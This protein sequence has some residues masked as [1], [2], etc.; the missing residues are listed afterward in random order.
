MARYCGRNF[1]TH[2]NCVR[3]G[4]PITRKLHQSNRWIGHQIRHLKC[5]RSEGS[6]YERDYDAAGLRTRSAA[7][8]NKGIVR[9]RSGICD[10]RA[11]RY[12]EGGTGGVFG[13]ERGSSALVL[14]K[15]DGPG[16]CAMD[17]SATYSSTTAFT[18]FLGRSTSMPRLTAS[19]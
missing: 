19:V 6:N 10:P 18:R 3:S 11:Q 7:S 9:N 17:S 1:S 15:K 2:G 4:E 13:G 12:K 14:Q 8:D 16:D 5:T